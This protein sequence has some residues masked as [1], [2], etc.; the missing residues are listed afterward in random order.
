MLVLERKSGESVLIYPDESIDPN[1]R[2]S[3]LFSNG[4]I[5]ISVRCKQKAA[6]KLAISAPDSIKILRKEIQKHSQ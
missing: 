6:I 3:D 2:V 1:M 4:P 5:H